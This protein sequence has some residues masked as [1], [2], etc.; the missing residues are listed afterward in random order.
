MS[1][2]KDKE[3]FRGSCMPSMT[4]HNAASVKL[5]KYSPPNIIVRFLKIFVHESIGAE[6]LLLFE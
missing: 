5:T 2:K 1:E 6:L 3:K 4:E